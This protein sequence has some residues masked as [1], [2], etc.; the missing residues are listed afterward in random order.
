MLCVGTLGMVEGTLIVEEAFVRGQAMMSLR[1]VHGEEDL[2]HVVDNPAAAAAWGRTPAELQGALDS[3]LGLPRG[4]RRSLIRRAR[5]ARASGQPHDIELT[6]DTPRGQRSFA[7][8]VVAVGGSEGAAERFWLIVE[9]ATEQRGLE[10]ALARAERLAGWRALRQVGSSALHRP[11][12]GALVELSR[13][14]Q[15]LE[16][17]QLLLQREAYLAMQDALLAATSH[18]ER[19]ARA[20]RELEW[21]ALEPHEPL[22]REEKLDAS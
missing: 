16:E 14:R 1:E 21:L 19:L 6:C 9:D 13:A 20:L 15:Q 7:G 12:T 3:A 11:T 10:V 8:K 22:E 17:Q 18:I 4:C 5:R 2:R